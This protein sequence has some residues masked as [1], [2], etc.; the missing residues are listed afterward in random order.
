MIIKTTR[1]DATVK[2]VNNTLRHVLDKHHEN[3]F[4][5]TA[6]GSRQDVYDALSDAQT[7][8]RKSSLFQVILSSKENLSHTQFEDC[9]RRHGREYGYGSADIALYVCHG[10][11][12]HDGEA[13]DFHYHAFVRMHNPETRKRLDITDAYARNEKVA[14]E[15]ESAHGLKITNGRHND[16]VIQ[17]TNDKSLKEKLTEFGREKPE[18]AFSSRSKEAAKRRGV[19][20]AEVK[21]QLRDDFH[22]SGGSWSGFL[23]RV[24]A[25]GWRVGA[26]TKKADITVVYDAE[27]KALGSVG[28]MLGLRKNELADVMSG[29]AIHKKTE[30]TK[31]NDKPVNLEFVRGNVDSDKRLASDGSVKTKHSKIH[32]NHGH[33]THQRLQANRAGYVPGLSKEIIAANEVKEALERQATD[34]V[35]E[36][37]KR[38]ESESHSNPFFI[39]S[40]VPARAGGNQRTQ[41]MNT[42]N[43]RPEPVD[44]GAGMRFYYPENMPDAPMAGHV[45]VKHEDYIY[46]IPKKHSPARD[47][48][49]LTWNLEYDPAGQLR[50]AKN[51]G[52][53]KDMFRDVLSARSAKAREALNQP[54]PDSAIP[55]ILSGKNHGERVRKVVES[56]HDKLRQ[57]I[58]EEEKARIELEKVKGSFF[59]LRK[60]AAKEKEDELSEKM[61]QVAMYA[62]WMVKKLLSKCGIGKDPGP[63]T[64]LTPGQKQEMAEEYHKNK[65]A[66]LLVKATKA[67][68]DCSPEIAAAIVRDAENKQKQWDERPEAVKRRAEISKLEGLTQGVLDTIANFPD[69]PFHNNLSDMLLRRLKNGSDSEV[70]DIIDEIRDDE[71]TR[72]TAA[73]QILA[74]VSDAYADEHALPPTHEEIAIQKRIA[75]L[76]EMEDESDEL[77][78]RKKKRNHNGMKYEM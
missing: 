19:D 70:R 75:A 7:F 16:Y 14:R 9:L 56:S 55:E 40:S 68:Q 54:H 48:R 60:N 5:R 42:Q 26:G 30:N 1:V 23:E 63:F 65:L 34:I 6:H 76:E 74:D 46:E 36:N 77:E 15:F 22:A 39:I 41:K 47:V 43:Y 67:K 20:L 18:S 31:T 13:C 4:I 62:V 37:I 61:R 28:R 27:G 11:D 58:E 12:R 35:N 29:V 53:I 8:G 44:D 50:G 2:A 25:R 73:E 51:S 21:M 78:G 59:G 69:S 24:E 64:S 3:N 49:G 10:K 33:S 32:V 66:Q 52:E 45:F 72:R 57:Y 71:E 38:M 17:H